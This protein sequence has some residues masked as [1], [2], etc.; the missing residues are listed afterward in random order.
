MGLTCGTQ[1]TWDRVHWDSG[2]VSLALAKTGGVTTLLSWPPVTTELHLAA[3]SV[4]GLGC[5]PGQGEVPGSARCRVL[6]GFGLSSTDSRGRPRGTRSVLF[7]SG[8]PWARTPGQ[9]LA[10]TSAKWDTVSELL[11]RA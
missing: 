5:G 3:G 6:Q 9:T 8:F 1:H 2:S 11:L 7:G 4:W 10:M